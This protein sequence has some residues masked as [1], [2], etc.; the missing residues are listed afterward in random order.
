M[1][2]I[3][4]I[5]WTIFASVLIYARIVFV[6]GVNP[7]ATGLVNL[8]LV[9]ILVWIIYAIS[10]TSFLKLKIFYATVFVVFLGAALLLA[11]VKMRQLTNFQR[12]TYIPQPQ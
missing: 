2:N 1:Y 4:I 10:K 5:V 8:A 11:N 12:K 6:S 9:A 7:L 3:K